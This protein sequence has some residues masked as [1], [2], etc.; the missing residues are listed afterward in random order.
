[1]TEHKYIAVASPASIITK[2][3]ALLMQS[4]SAGQVDVSAMWQPKTS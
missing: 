3:H 1:M 2:V 4:E